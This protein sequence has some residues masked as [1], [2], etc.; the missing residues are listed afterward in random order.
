M[1]I[2]EE[3]D[4]EKRGT[5]SLKSFLKSFSFSIYNDVRFK[6]YSLCR[7]TRSSK[8]NDIVIFIFG[9]LSWE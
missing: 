8:L 2:L 4:S 1:G 5:P 9:N 3:D 6:S 7:I